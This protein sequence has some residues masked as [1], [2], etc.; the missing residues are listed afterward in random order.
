M[1]FKE[2]IEAKRKGARERAAAEKKL[3]AEQQ[4]AVEHFQSSK[5]QQIV[6]LRDKVVWP[7]MKEFAAA[8][9]LH[10]PRT[11]NIQRSQHDP[12]VSGRSSADI[13]P[14]RVS[15][16][17][18]H[19]LQGLKI[20]AWV[21]HVSDRNV[22][23]MEVS[24]NTVPHKFN[25]LQIAECV[26]R[27]LMDVAERLELLLAATRPGGDSLM[28]PPVGK[29][30]ETSTDT[31]GLERRRVQRTVRRQEDIIQVF[32][33][34]PWLVLRNEVTVAQ[35]MTKQV[36]CVSPQYGVE[37]VAAAIKA[38]QARHL[39]VTGD[40]GNLCGVISRSDLLERTGKTAADIMTS[41][42][43]HIEPQTTLSVAAKLMVDHVIDCL[44][45]TEQGIIKGI[46]T[47]TDLMMAFQGALQVVSQAVE[48][49]MSPPREKVAIA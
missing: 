23:P 7:L 41:P 48:A 5:F 39:M 18:S 33:R 4:S 9:G 42:V 49:G 24:S 13:G 29:G 12:S 30:R 47:A 19:C 16:L 14:F 43:I 44:P 38:L 27:V 46:I 8:F 32:A 15:V 25:E 6:K 31:S 21:N 17:L 20:Q 26:K 3:L 36:R 34:N 10:S 2:R 22:P 1:S 40:D 45:I 11:T 37:K 28:P 35:V